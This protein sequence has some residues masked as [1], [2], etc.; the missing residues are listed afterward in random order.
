MKHYYHC[1]SKGLEDE[2]LFR[3]EEEFIAGMNRIGLCYLLSLKSHPVIILAFCLMDNHVHFI[4]YGTYEDCIRFMD[5]YKKLTGLWLAFH[6]D[7]KGILKDWKHEA[8]LIP[9]AEMLKEKMAYVHRN[10]IVAN[11]NLVPNGYRWSSASLYFTDKSMFSKI[12]LPVNGLSQRE[13]RSLFNT[14]IEFPD[15]WRYLPGGEIWPGCYTEFKRIEAVFKTA[16]NYQYEMNKR[17]EE[18]VNSEIMAE[19]VSLPDGDVLKM[20][21][22]I[23]ARMFGEYDI[24]LLTVKQRIKLCMALRKEV[25]GNI[26][27]LSRI[28]HIQLK[29]LREIIG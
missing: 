27:Q 4:L 10:P 11:I 25:G 13:R 3:T 2:I 18:K 7:K 14:K 12:L 5:D 1:A 6:R 28:V 22:E 23:S 26:G 8:W 20:A 29:E 21:S 15:D 19:R 9:N 24:D 16:W 17:V